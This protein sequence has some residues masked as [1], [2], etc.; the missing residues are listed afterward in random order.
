MTVLPPELPWL[1]GSLKE[2]KSK[3]VNKTQV[4]AFSQGRNCLYII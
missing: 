3:E 2:N 1:L 4:L